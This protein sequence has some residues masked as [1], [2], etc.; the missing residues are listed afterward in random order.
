M[1]EKQLVRQSVVFF[2]KKQELENQNTEYEDVTDY[3]ETLATESNEP[4]KRHD[5]SKEPEQD[6]RRRYTIMG[7]CLL[8]DEKK[9][10]Y[11][12]INTPSKGQGND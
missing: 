10:R 9:E 5:E 2:D 12:Q 8:N 7:D 3:F 4:F 6:L 1:H 11:S